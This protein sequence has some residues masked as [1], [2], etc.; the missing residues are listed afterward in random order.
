MFIPV[1][2]V[3]RRPWLRLKAKTMAFMKQV[4]RSEERIVREWRQEV[5]I[6]DL[7]GELDPEFGKSRGH[8]YVFFSTW[9][10]LDLIPG[11][12]HSGKS[13][14]TKISSF[15]RTSPVSLNGPICE[16]PNI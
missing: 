11:P 2:V 12:P 4:N 14:H 7:N 6:H 10:K 15:S 1:E 16:E 8:L 5:E 3:V 13:K 9:L